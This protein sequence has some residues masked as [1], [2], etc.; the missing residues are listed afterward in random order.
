[1]EYERKEKQKE[2]DMKIIAVREL[3]KVKN[4]FIV[5]VKNEPIK[6]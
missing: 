2:A 3:E 1:L 6:V 4:I 5:G